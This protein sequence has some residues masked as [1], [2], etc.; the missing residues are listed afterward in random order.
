[1]RT[2]EPRTGLSLA[3]TPKQTGPTLVEETGCLEP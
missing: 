3:E 2:A 1:M